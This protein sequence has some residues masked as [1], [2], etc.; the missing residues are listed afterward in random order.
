MFTLFPPRL[1]VSLLSLAAAAL[2]GAC[3]S[4]PGDRSA[5]IERAEPSGAAALALSQSTSAEGEL[6]AGWR[7]WI[8]RRDKAPTHY[9]LAR[10]RIGDEERLV[11]HAV[12][13]AA[14]SGA[15]VPLGLRALD[16]PYVRWSWRTDAP[17][18]RA[19]SS[20]PETEDA[21]ARLVLAFDGD[22]SKL[23]LREQ[24]LAETARMLLGQEVP[25]AT[26]IYTW[27]ARLPVGATLVNAHSTRVR[28]KVVE[29]GDA[30]VGQWLEYERNYVQD[31]VEL[32]G[33]APGR[34]I[35]IGVMTDT[36]NTRSFAESW[37]GDIQLLTPSRM[38]LRELPD[39]PVID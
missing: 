38:A 13:K 27:D 4:T 12:A 35:G 37:Y 7:S 26:L 18:E 10:V 8:I 24:M 9:R 36:D 25:Y 22:W 5:E 3:A 6:P 16:A 29:S 19:D 21:P 2:L 20:R 30:G 15:W 11:L 39:G 34:L 28:M 1:R 17:I 33:E 14:A 32:F 31:Y 23:P